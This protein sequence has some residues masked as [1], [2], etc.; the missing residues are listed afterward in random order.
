MTNLGIK[1]IPK[2]LKYIANALDNSTHIEFYLNWIQHI[3]TQYGAKIKSQERMT[4]LL[5]MQKSLTRKYEQLSK[6]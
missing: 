6:M 3:L 4:V 5:N 1:Y 2:M